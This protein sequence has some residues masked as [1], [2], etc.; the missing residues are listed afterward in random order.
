M[1]L[2][3]EFLEKL[4]TE[5]ETVEFSNTMAVIEAYYTFTESAFSNGQQHNAAG[6]NSG[7]CKIFS[8]SQLN[9]LSEAQ[10]LACFGSY[11]RDDVLGFPDATDH[12][13][14]R[15]FIANGWA[16]IRFSDNALTS[17]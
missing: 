2:L 8:F 6:E 10:T 9:G 1:M 17:K 12:Q 11:Y 5:A 14:I 3:S 4:T 13:N 7:S 16:G 15:Q